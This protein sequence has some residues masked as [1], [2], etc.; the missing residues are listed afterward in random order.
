MWQ[1]DLSGSRFASH[2]AINPDNA[3]Q[4]QLKWAFTFPS[5]PGVYP[6]SQPAVVDGTL[7][8]GSTDA[9][10][11][12]LD[13]RTGAVRWSY[14]LTTVAGPWTT[15]QPDPVRDGPAVVGNTVYF[16]DSRGYVYALNRYTGQLRWAT[17]LDRTN[18]DVRITS[19]P[20]VFD[21]RVYIGLSNQEGGYQT[22]NLNYPCCT[23]RGQFVALNART[24]SVIWRY[25]TVPPATAVGTWPDGATEYAPSGGSVWD[26]PVI[27]P[28]SRTIYL[29]TGQNYTGTEGDTD[30][31]IA[32]DLG[33]GH[34]RWRFK[35][36]ADTY[37]DVCGEPQY[38]AYC[39][40][41]ADGTAH[42]WDFGASPNLFRV[43]GRLVL[44]IGEKSG[45]Y[46]AFDAA[47]GKLLW[48][49]SLSADPNS[50]GGDG[51]VQWGTSYDGQRLYVATWIDKPNGNVFALDPA[52]GAI[53][54]ETAGP[55]DGCTTGGAA[56]AAG[57]KLAFT[58]A[59]TS[60]PGLVY[61]GSADGKMYVFSAATGRLLWQYDTVRSFNGVNGVAG[62]G[63]SI[64]GVGGAVVAEGMVYVQ[65][66]YYPLRSAPNTGTVLLA[67]GLP[68]N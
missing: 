64:S 66:G 49:R 37:T 29:G 20:I 5:I 4:L 39:P 35:A 48:S 19:S 34:V 2:S 44:G 68:G 14:G 11:Y 60:S 3:G 41:A 21:G 51:G 13:A 53:L 9:K 61:E 12:A 25:Y 54:W 36:Q 28:A 17:L 10:F 38:L 18:P 24:G 32:L 23:A 56:S 65:S 6:G 55:A 58:P 26:S 7:Y 62:H 42:D 57:C 67:F 33:N 43:H 31:V 46:R 47:T 50:A 59:V 1:K 8:V 22:T 16:G 45:V 40:G 63:E 15:A 52:T 27:D 30:S